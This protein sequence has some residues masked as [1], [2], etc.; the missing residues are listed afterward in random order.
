MEDSI[1]LTRPGTALRISVFN[2]FTK[3]ISY[4][5]RLGE[6]DLLYDLME[7]D[8]NFDAIKSDII[9]YINMDQDPRLFHELMHLTDT[10]SIHQYIIKSNDEE[11]NAWLSLAADCIEQLQQFGNEMYRSRNNQY[12]NLIPILAN[13]K[14]VE[15][16]NRAV[17]EGLLDKDFQPIESTSMFQL[18]LI[19]IAV[20]E[21][22]NMPNRNRWCKFEEQWNLTGRRL[23]GISFPLGKSPEIFRVIKLYPEIN[24]M[25]YMTNQAEPS[26]TLKTSL[27]LKQ[28]KKLF[29]KLME[30]GFLDKNTKEET[31]LAFLGFIKMPFTRINWIAPTQYSLIYFSHSL[32][33]DLNARWIKP[34][35]KSFTVNGN[36]LN[37]ETVKSRNSY[38]HRHRDQYEFINQID[39]ILKTIAK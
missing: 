6:E 1:E 29:G 22:T 20:M 4:A 26:V 24:F 8:L 21:I 17:K 34:V 5:T 35:C 25:K 31:F 38:I 16:L 30:E 19:A 10:E 11:L 15:L 14:T 37:A 36:E 9:T 28:A 13:D 32:F 18:K 39:N 7:Q 33:S 3:Q 23:S 27:S 2:K 12:H